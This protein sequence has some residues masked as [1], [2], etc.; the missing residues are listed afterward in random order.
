MEKLIIF[1]L[2]SLW[3]TLLA[4]LVFSSFYCVLQKCINKLYELVSSKNN[5]KEVYNNN[6]DKQK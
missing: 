2:Y 6:K 1:H 3:S 4:Y 5:N